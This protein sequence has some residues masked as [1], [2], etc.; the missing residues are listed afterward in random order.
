MLA[1]LLLLVLTL[2]LAA[3]GAAQL[4]A[5]PISLTLSPSQT[6]TPANPPPTE[7]GKA[8][9]AF[10]KGDLEGTLRWLQRAQEE[11]K[12]LAPAKVM[13]ANIYFSNEQPAKGREA[14]EQ[15][16]VMHPADP[17][18]HLIFGDLAW[19]ERRLSDAQVQYER[20]G[21]LTSKFTGSPE[22]K[23]QLEIRALAGLGNVAEARG[24]IQAAHK[25]FSALIA[26]EPKH[27]H[28]HYRLGVVLF[29]QGRPD[30]ALAEFREA[31]KLLE[32]APSAP[33]TLAD[34]YTRAGDAEKGQ[35]WIEQAIDESPKDIRPLLAMARWQLEFR[36]D[37]QVAAEV[38]DRAAKLD[39][40]SSEVR[41]F[42]GLIAWC[43]GDHTQ[44]EKMFESIVLAEPG[45]ATA[46]CYLAAVLAEQNDADR[47]RRAWEVA[48]LAAA[49]N[50]RAVDT[51]ATLGWVA[52]HRGELE[53]AEQQLQLATSAGGVT[54]DTNYYL[55][56]TMFRR[57]Q[58]AKAQQALRQALAAEGL[59]IHLREAREWQKELGEPDS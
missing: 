38:V 55:A 13:L 48:Q 35:R 52:Y 45:N 57:G 9:A 19:R 2:C 5:A 28:A 16:V 32:T 43:Q 51:A 3:L 6:G 27:P 29:S 7:V 42:R 34:L 17:E 25:Y 54:R 33:L 36:N 20:G 22:R 10:H 49:T 12:E 30:E 4:P 23:R 37:P 8:I 26:L 59:F 53:Q 11:H 24:Q 31:A 15:A 46:N 56:R 14:L 58:I 39:S 40:E 1:H 18:P 41:F 21:Q 50:A 47:R 44:A